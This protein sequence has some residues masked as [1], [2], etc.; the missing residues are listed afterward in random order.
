[1]GVLVHPNTEVHAAVQLAVGGGSLRIVAEHHSGNP[2]LLAR[3]GECSLT[4]VR[5]K[6]LDVVILSL[7]DSETATAVVLLAHGRRALEDLDDLPGLLSESAIVIAK[8]SEGANRIEGSRDGSR[9]AV[10]LQEGTAVF[11]SD[12]SALLAEVFSIELDHPERFE[13]SALS[14]VPSGTWLHVREGVVPRVRV[15]RCP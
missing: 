13:L 7:L 1:M 8:D 6:H 9:R 14:I 3:P 10:W 5:T 15:A 12:E 11:A 4:E 2:W